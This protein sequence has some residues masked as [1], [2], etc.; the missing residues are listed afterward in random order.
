MPTQR[1]SI[2]SI[3]VLTPQ[4]EHR[5]I[6]LIVNESVKFSIEIYPQDDRPNRWSC[7]R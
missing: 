5:D 3:V 6:L 4:M 2:P 1:T 7:R